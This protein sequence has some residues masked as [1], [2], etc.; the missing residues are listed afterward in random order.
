MDHLSDLQLTAWDQSLSSEKVS[1]QLSELAH[2]P[3]LED[4]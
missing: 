2:L 3:H 1:P 4:R